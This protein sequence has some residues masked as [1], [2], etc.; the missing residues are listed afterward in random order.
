MK[1]RLLFTGLVLALVLTTF[2]PAAAMAAKPVDFGASGIITYIELGGS[3][4][5]AG[6]SDRWRVA[7]RYLEGTFLPGGD[8]NGDFTL[9]Y[10][11]N[12]DST[13][14]GNLHGTITVVGEDS[15]VL[16]VNGKIE[17]LEIVWFE[18]LGTYLPKLTISGHWTFTDGARGQGDF[19]ASLIFIPS[20][21]HVGMVV[22]GAFDMTGKWQP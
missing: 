11:A 14:A 15:Y 18:P 13:Q 21:E 17:P 1:K 8:I 5:P 9:A 6:D 7:S 12:V 2:V 16:K 10:K 3:V 19:D 22:A 20:G 4:F